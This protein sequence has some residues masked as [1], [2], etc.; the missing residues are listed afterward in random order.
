MGI[1]CTLCDVTVT[2]Q[3]TSSTRNYPISPLTLITK[4]S[5]SKY[6]ISL[7]TCAAFATYNIN[8][9]TSSKWPIGGGNPEAKWR[10]HFWWEKI[11]WGLDSIVVAPHSF[12]VWWGG[13][14]K[15]CILLNIKD[16]KIRTSEL[17][18]KLNINYQMTP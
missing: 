15:K 13:G 7:S 5:N 9:R 6:L 8:H 12:L 2:W 1:S 10:K 4:Q 11:Y 3:S 16:T 17:I 14:Y 18:F